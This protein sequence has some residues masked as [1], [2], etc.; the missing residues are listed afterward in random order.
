MYY[1]ITVNG[2]KCAIPLIEL[3][4]GNGSTSDDGSY[5]EGR[6]AGLAEAADKVNTAKAEAATAKAEA[7]TAKAEATAAKTAQAT[8]EAAEAAAKKAQ[9]TAEQERDAAIEAHED[10][11]TTISGL[12]SQITTLN[13]TISQLESEGHEGCLYDGQTAAY[14]HG[15]W[16]SVNTEHQ[17]CTVGGK[18]ASQWK[19]EYDDLAGEH[20]NC[21]STIAELEANQTYEGMTAKE[22]ANHS[23]EINQLL[24]FAVADREA[25]KNACKTAH[26]AAVITGNGS[27]LLEFDC[28][29]DP[30]YICVVNNSPDMLTVANRTTY[31]AIDRASLGYYSAFASASLADLNASGLPQYKNLVYK[32]ATA[33]DIVAVTDNE[34][35]TKHVKVFNVMLVAPTATTEA[36]YA[37]FAS[38]VEYLVVAV[39][40]LT[41]SVEERIEESVERLPDDASLEVWYREPKLIE[42][43]GEG[44]ADNQDWIDLQARKPDVTFHVV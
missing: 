19:Q 17:N 38:G 34:D 21:E 11:A 35:G 32:P 28:Q 29:F 22:W 7:A 30:D 10:C 8:A 20:A 42:A 26:Y 36:V 12:N 3:P 14:W 40:T 1:E 37:T 27:P 33:D 6:Q 13:E 41:K 15:Q 4:D 18:T 39:K 23:E 44:Y 24:N 31:V 25:A 5:E 9:A 16:N 43:Y 2:K